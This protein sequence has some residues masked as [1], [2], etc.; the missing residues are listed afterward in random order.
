VWVERKNNEIARD[1]KVAKKTS[2]DFRHL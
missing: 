1:E 2:P